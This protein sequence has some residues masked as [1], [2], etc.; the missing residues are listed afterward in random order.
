MDFTGGLSA[1]KGCLSLL[2]GVGRDR[3]AQWSEAPSVERK[4]FFGN[5]STVGYEVYKHNNECQAIEVIGQDWSSEVVVLF[6]K[7]WELGRVVLSCHMTMDVLCW[8]SS[9][10]LG[11]LSSYQPI[12]FCLLLHYLSA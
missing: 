5:E 12:E 11:S 4:S 2:V 9:E 3:R 1:L 6:L 8:D 10:S 7:D